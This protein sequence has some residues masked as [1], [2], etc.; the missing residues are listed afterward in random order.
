MANEEKKKKNKD[1]KKKPTALKRCLQDKKKNLANKVYCSKVKS[2]MRSYKE[3]VEK[4]ESEASRKALLN[5]TFSLLDKAT[6]KGIYKKNTASR[7]KSRL[8]ALK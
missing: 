2:A 1:K 5:T 7:F 4:K 3:A 6:K 8:S